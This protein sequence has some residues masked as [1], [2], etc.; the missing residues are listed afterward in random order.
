VILT[1]AEFDEL[2]VGQWIHIEQLDVG[3]W[4]MNIGGVTI[5]VAA[6]R[7]GRP[8]SV[9]IDG[10]GHY[11]DPRAGCTYELRAWTDVPSGSLQPPVTPPA[12]SATPETATALSAPRK[13]N[14]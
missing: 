8:K 14:G 13:G 3:L 5:H 11:D 10:P 2:V 4:W 6:D 7:D 12:H 9:T 1:G